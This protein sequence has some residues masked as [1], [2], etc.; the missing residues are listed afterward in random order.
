[1]AKFE[2]GCMYEPYASELEPIKII[3]RTNKTIWAKNECTE[4]MM[5]IKKDEYGNE[6]AVDSSVPNKWREAFTYKAE[7]TV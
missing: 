2:V 1:M 3:R 6:Y 4:W 5:R 7:W